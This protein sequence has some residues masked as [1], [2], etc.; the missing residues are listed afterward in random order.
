MK[1]SKIDNQLTSI[2]PKT[3]YPRQR[4]IIRTFTKYKTLNT[5]FSESIKEMA[6]GFQ[7]FT[8]TCPT[9]TSGREGYENFGDSIKKDLDTYYYRQCEASNYKCVMIPGIKSSALNFEN[10]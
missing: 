8:C 9:D 2:S 10:T 5:V 3:R 7:V 6:N 4:E 1:S